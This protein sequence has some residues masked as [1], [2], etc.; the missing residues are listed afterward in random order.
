MNWKT[1]DNEQ[2]NKK[3]EW[4]DIESG[5]LPPCWTV[6]NIFVACPGI[7]SPLKAV[8][9]MNDKCFHVDFGPV[10]KT[11]NFYKSDDFYNKELDLKIKYWIP[12]AVPFDFQALREAN[13]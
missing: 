6:F 10:R 7:P 8:Y 5:E 3:V 9:S 4:I 2:Q 11:I 1:C 12:L 13:D